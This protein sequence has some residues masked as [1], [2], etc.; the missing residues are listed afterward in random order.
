[1]I[2]PCKKLKEKFETLLSGKSIRSRIDE[3]VV[4]SQLSLDESAIWNLFVASGYLKIKKQFQ[5]ESPAEWKQIH[6]LEIT[7]F[8]VML[9][10]RNL[11]HEWF[12]RSES[13]YNDFITAM[14]SGDLE[15]MNVFMN[16]IAQS[17]FSFFDSGNKPSA[18]S[19]PESFTMGLCRG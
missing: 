19:E 10:F 11:V 12:A 15:A 1:M 2:R 9:M 14:L 7:N 6:E 3:Q 13:N 17:V 4:Y 5:I 18:E 16:R 8:E